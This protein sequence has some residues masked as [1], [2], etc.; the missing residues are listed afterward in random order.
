MDRLDQLKALLQDKPDDSFLLF[1][2]AKE[3]EK[4]GNEALALE[5]YL[6]LRTSNPDYVGLYYHLGKLYEELEQSDEAREAYQEGIDLAR[7]LGNHH[8]LS[9][10]QGALLNL[11]LS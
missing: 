4:A 9:E 5:W 1:A 3:Y 6:K 10:L 2:V 7:R 11:D 8:A